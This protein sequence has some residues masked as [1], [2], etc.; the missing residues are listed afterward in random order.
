MGVGK[1]Y[2]KKRNVTKRG[3][4]KMWITNVLRGLFAR[5]EEVKNGK[6]PD[7]NPR[8]ESGRTE[9]KGKTEAVKE[10]NRMEE[11]KA[12]AG[13]GANTCYD[14]RELSWLKFNT[15]V[16]EEAEDVNNPFC[17]RLSFASI[18][19]SN[20]DEFF[21]VR[22]GSL[23]DQMLVSKEIRDN[24]TNMTCQEQL[25]AIFDQVKLLTQR[26]DAAY[27]DLKKG[28]ENYGIEIF[29]YA[30]M[31]D[32]D[33]RF[34]DAYFENEIRPLLSPQIIGK[35]QPFPF[36]KNKDIYAV[37]VLEKKGRDKLGIVPCK[38]DVFPRLVKIPNHANRFML[39][40]ELILHYIPRVFERYEI[41]SKSLIRII[42]NADIDPDEEMY[43]D[44]TDFRQVMEQLVS[45]RR[46]LCPIKL[47]Y[48]RLM[49]ASVLDKLCKYLGL[50]KKHIFHSE[51]PL[52]LSFFSKFRDLLR[53]NKELFY[54]KFTP[55]IPAELDMGKSMMAQVEE[56]DRFLFF[57]YDSM[58]PFL[59][60][61]NEAAYDPRVVSVK[62]TLYRVANDSKVVEA[63]IR[64]AENGKEVVVL[65]ELRARF[66]EEN[67]IEWSRR[68]EDAGCRILYG[69]DKLKVH[70]KLCLITLKTEDHISYIT[71]IGTG[72]YNEKT[73]KLYTDFS[74]MT[75]HQG[76]GEEANEVFQRLCLGQVMTETKY[77]MV[78]PKCLRNKI[79]ERIDGQIELAKKGKPAYVGAKM[80][81]LTDKCII[82]KL[83]EASQAGVEVELIVRGS[84]C[85]IAGVPG[86]TDNITVRSIV[87]R[88]LEHSRIYIFG[89]DD[90][91]IA[92]ADFM[93][94]NTTRRVEVAAPVYDE[95]IKKRILHIFH[96][97]MADN[98]KAR[99]QLAD[100]QYI[101]AFRET[102]P[103]NAQSYFSR[104]W[105]SD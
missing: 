48:T 65:V 28:L 94:R 99:I 6:E 36:L 89:N 12:L 3:L 24:K 92:S 88:Y 16:L 62:M 46:K 103:L 96:V 80:N 8:Q 85:L 64:A 76:I 105:D 31:D 30:E 51:A 97:L 102:E 29:S 14:N 22:V 71:Q 45:R 20:L 58:E 33:V 83:M 32:E 39:M 100:G 5:R 81:S 42:R 74:L 82:E 27:E 9:T 17:E 18:F 93:T 13:N 67:N 95:D 7:Q 66:D 23:Y 84:C 47:E 55:Q 21:M 15:R 1:L 87:G 2:N 50:K 4:S 54:D 44:D 79:M 59:R 104:R 86:V 78:A 26:K 19:Q 43:D 101:K 52:D 70:S 60:M 77:L 10:Q 91:Y 90:V 69:L 11:M 68:L 73:A 37:V 25:F 56:K 40:E 53:G 34:L 72:N 49:D 38:V 98:V 57:P 35:K 63:L 75:A 41:K 61:L